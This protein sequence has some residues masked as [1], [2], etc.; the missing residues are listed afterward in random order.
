VIES[1]VKM[2]GALTIGFIAACLISYALVFTVHYILVRTQSLKFLAKT[3]WNF[4]STL[5]EYKRKYPDYPYVMCLFER[6]T[7]KIL[8][9]QELT[10]NFETKEEIEAF[11]VEFKTKLAKQKEAGK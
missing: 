11:F 9:A 4:Y 3:M 5:P 2:I 7:G 10:Q 1:I 8:H 6:K